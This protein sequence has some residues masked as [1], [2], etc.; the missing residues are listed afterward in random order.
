MPTNINLPRGKHCF[1]WRSWKVYDYHEVEKGATDIPACDGCASLRDITK[2]QNYA[3]IEGLAP[4]VYQISTAR[5][6]NRLFLAQRIERLA[7]NYASKAH[8]EEVYDVVVALGERYGYQVYRRDVSAQDVMENKLVDFGTFSLTPDHKDKI[9][10]MYASYARY[11]KQYY[12]DLPELGV[13]G[14]PRNNKAR[15]GWMNLE[16]LPFAG[17]SVADLG[18]SG[19]FFTRYAVDRGAS[20]ADG[21]DLNGEGNGQPVKAAR[22]AANELEYWSIDYHDQD[23]TKTEPKPADIVFFLSMNYHI[24]IP[25]WLPEVTKEVCVFEDNSKARNAEEQLKT[26]FR[27]V[28][29]VGTALDHGDKP[30]IWC[31]K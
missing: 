6:F 25:K 31:I 8:A 28:R 9:A 4:R 29:R 21:Y 2:V 13:Q 26:M 17:K 5:F 20:V 12:H 7:E 14:G 3:A 23:L 27:E 16:N 19:G 22:I 1:I 11:G 30:V 24:G 18:C 15:V 10:S